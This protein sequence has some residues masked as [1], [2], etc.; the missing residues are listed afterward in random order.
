MDVSNIE[1]KKLGNWEI[2]TRLLSLCSGSMWVALSVVIFNVLFHV[3]NIIGLNYIGVGIDYLIHHFQ[4]EQTVIRWPF[5]WDFSKGLEHLEVAFLIF[6]AIIGVGILKF[7]SQ[8]VSAERLAVLVHKR[9]IPKLQNQVFRK[10]QNLSF[11]FF[12][13]ESSGAIINKASGDV[14]SVRSFVDTVLV[15]GLTLMI[16]TVLYAS[17]MLLIHPR[18]AMLCMG[19]IPLMFVAVF[20]FSRIVRPRMLLSRELFDKLVLALSENVEGIKT[21]KGLSLENHLAEDLHRKNDDV[22]RQQRRVFWC[23]SSFSPTFNFLSQVGIVVLLI[24]GGKLA[25]DGE[26]AI[27]TGLVVFA[28]LLQQFSNQITSFSHLISAIQ[29]SFTSAQRIFSLMDTPVPVSQPEKP[30]EVKHIDGDVRFEDVSFEFV[31]NKTA[32]H[33]ISFDVKKGTCVAIMGETGSGKSALLHL[34]ARFYDPRS[35]K[36][37]ID[38]I[39]AKEL[40]L[41][42]VRHS[43]GVLFQESFLFADT[44]LNNLKF[45][46]RDATM[47]EVIEAAKK[48]HA[49][50]FITALEKGYDSMVQEGAKNLSGGQRQRLGLAR[51]LLSNPSILILDDPS[52]AVD[53]KTEK[54]IFEAI[55]DTISTRTTFMVAHRVTTLR[56]ADRILVLKKGRVIQDGSHDELL[57]QEGPYRDA[58]LIQLEYNEKPKTS[59]AEREELKSW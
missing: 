18:L 28:S 1:E 42:L 54:A 26:I 22:E 9:I 43:V 27:G 51:V 33:D 48:A 17:N 46:N 19:A 37:C 31:E 57:N 56:R 12:D 14:S 47:E 6:S 36:V 53:S 29:E 45:G 32:L 55:E 21:V 49:H 50:S 40:D 3:W 7:V 24:Y 11:S 5:G 4:D 8:L 16:T 25:I 2:F 13:R 39:D 44:I 23:I 59:V 15:E 34:I 58:A 20:I 35:G 30:R 41:E 38:G 52:S 10:L